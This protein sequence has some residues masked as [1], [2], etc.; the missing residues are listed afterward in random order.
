M[1]NKKRLQDLKESIEYNRNVHGEYYESPITCDV[2]EEL[3]TEVEQLRDRDLF[4]SCLEQ[5]GVDKAW[6]EL[7]E[8]KRLVEYKR[9]EEAEYDR[10][11]FINK[12]SDLRKQKSEIRDMLKVSILR[13][14]IREEQL[15]ASQA[16]VAKEKDRGDEYDRQLVE[17]H[18][19]LTATQTRC[20]AM[21]NANTDLR[22]QSAEASRCKEQL[23]DMDY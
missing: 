19:T 16:E 3:I 20:L 22:N 12:C 14:N 13:C 4:L 6:A 15:A 8:A 7:A 5:G 18:D 9:Y 11:I 21:E 2:L 17:L 10:D 1:L 23:L